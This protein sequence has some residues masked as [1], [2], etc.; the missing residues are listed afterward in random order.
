MVGQPVEVAIAKLGYPTDEQVPG[1]KV[2][3]WRTGQLIEG[4]SVGCKIRAIIEG[5]V[6]ATWDFEGSQQGCSSYA[7]KL[8]R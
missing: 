1:W 7:W 4:T 2:Y 3:I 6:I 8:R 5:S